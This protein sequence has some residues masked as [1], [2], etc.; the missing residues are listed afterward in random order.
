[1]NGLYWQLKNNPVKINYNPPRGIT[2]DDIVE[3]YLYTIGYSIQGTE[4][5]LHEW[6]ELENAIQHFK[7]LMRYGLG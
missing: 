7:F 3:A 1:M 2:I 4:D 5:P 6:D